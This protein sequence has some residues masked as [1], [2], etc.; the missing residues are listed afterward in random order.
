MLKH[1]QTQW[2]ASVIACL[3]A[4]ANILGAQESVQHTVFFF[5]NLDEAFTLSLSFGFS[6]EESVYPMFSVGTP[7]R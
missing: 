1:T 4:A 5:G 6:D 7:L 2:F 3:L